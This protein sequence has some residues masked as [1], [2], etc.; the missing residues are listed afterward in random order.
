MIICAFL[1]VLSKDVDLSASTTSARAVCS[2][3][4]NNLRSSIVF[5]F[6]FR[7]FPSSR[8]TE[9]SKTKSWCLTYLRS[10]FK[11]NLVSALRISLSF[12]ENYI[13]SFVVTSSLSSS[14][15]VVVSSL[16]GVLYIFKKTPSFYGIRLP[17]A[18]S[19]SFSVSAVLTLQ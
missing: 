3:L 14:S 19:F 9:E 6:S 17:L 8:S 13:F 15:S 12:C 5:I 2:R 11:L 18:F 16:C 1:S 4:I 10:K 7:S